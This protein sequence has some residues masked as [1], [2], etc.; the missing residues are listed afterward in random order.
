[1]AQGYETYETSTP[2]DRLLDFRTTLFGLTPHVFN[3]HL[4]VAANA[5]VFVLMVLSEPEAI[6]APSRETLIRFGANFG[7]QTLGGEPWRLF[8]S[9]FVHIGI[10]HIALNM[11]VL[12]DIGRLMERVVGNTGF[13]V[14]YIISGLCGSVAS[15]AYNPYVLSAGASGAVFGLFG[16]LLGFLVLGRGC[17]PT[18]IVTSLRSSATAFVGYN[19]IFGFIIRGIDNAA[20]LGGFAGGCLCGLL[21]GQQLTLE[22]PVYRWPRNLAALIVGGGIVYAGV[23]VLPAP[24]DIERTLNALL[25]TEKETIEQY[26]RLVAQSH[27]GTL[28]AEQFGDAIERDLL[29]DWRQ[30]RQTLDNIRRPPQHLVTVI[31]TF[32]DYFQAREEKWELEVSALRHPDRDQQA[33]LERQEGQVQAALSRVNELM[34]GGARG[35][36]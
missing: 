2:Q 24:V 12:W 19:L 25:A 17:M 32:R 33:E 16:G 6:S 8:T 4:L 31:D 30:A 11:W 20:H 26:N 14:L 10:I 5:V 23:S 27:S 21:L 18:E 22:R 9:M 35:K 13:L 34:T 15:V 1:M 3:T 29:P 36:N 7:P 28:S